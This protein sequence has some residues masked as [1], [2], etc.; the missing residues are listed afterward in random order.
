MR[1]CHHVERLK[2]EVNMK[3]VV[4]LS[5]CVLLLV[6][7]QESSDM[8][9]MGSESDATRGSQIQDRAYRGATNLQGD[10]GAFTNQNQTNIGLQRSPG[11]HGGTAA[12]NGQPRE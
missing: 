2:V 10:S 6:G 11:T 1:F 4:V 3:R 5:G 8:G 9:G 12:P 7:C